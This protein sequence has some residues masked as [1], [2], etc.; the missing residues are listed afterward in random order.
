VYSHA[1]T[2]FSNLNTS[3]P[4]PRFVADS[5][6]HNKGL[7]EYL[8]VPYIIE[9]L[10]RGPALPSTCALM[11]ILKWSSASMRI[12]ILHQGGP[13]PAVKGVVKPFKPGGKC[14]SV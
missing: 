5:E 7:S 3:R 10:C 12:A 13:T 1:A 11:N 4:R 14:V 8:R 9:M 6:H 2:D